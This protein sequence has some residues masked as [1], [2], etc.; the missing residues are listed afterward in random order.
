MKERTLAHSS[1]FLMELILAVLF[2]SLG[3]A[4]C[5]QVFVNASLTSRAAKEESLGALLTSSAAEVLSGTDGTLES[6][7]VFFPQCTKVNGKWKIPY[8]KAG[9]PCTPKDDAVYFLVI[10]CTEPHA[11]ESYM[12]NA[13]ICFENT[14]GACLYHLDIRIAVPRTVSFGKVGD[15]S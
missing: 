7:Q 3:S 9:K 13:A 8:D 11:E 12:R 14:K 4:V 6:F 5:V 1:L 15:S 2:F 10:Q